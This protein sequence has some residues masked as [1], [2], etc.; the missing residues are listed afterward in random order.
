MPTPKQN[1]ENFVRKHK[2]RIEK[3]LAETH[4]AAG[5]KPIKLS[6]VRS[7][8]WDA[9][10]ELGYAK[11]CNAGDIWIWIMNTY[12]LLY[13]PKSLPGTGTARPRTKD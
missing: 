3:A 7:I 12:K 2:T 6:S 4:P 1:K 13:A 10:I 9:R 5:I 8:V 11:T